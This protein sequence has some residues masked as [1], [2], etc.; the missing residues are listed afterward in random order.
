MSETVEAKKEQAT[1]R[2]CGK[3]LRGNAY[4]Y[5]GRAYDDD[6]GREAKRNHYGGFVCSR[7]CDLRASLELEQS[8]PG[9]GITQRTLGC[10]SAD[11]L[12]RNWG[13]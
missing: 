1:C 7:R 9:H 8:M 6:T 2:G 5:G 11:A 10:F 13:E 4:M 3:L 12:R